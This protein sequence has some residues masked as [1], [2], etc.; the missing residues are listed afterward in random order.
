M[1]HQICIATAQTQNPDA[2]VHRRL[3]N[4]R[5]SLWGDHFLSYSN[6]SEETIDGLEQVQ[7]LKEEVQRMLMSPIDSL[8]EKL[9]LIDAIQRLGVSYHFEGEIDE[10][11]Q[12]IHRYHY[13]CDVQESD[14]ALYTIALHF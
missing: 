13:T 1:S 10:V 12:Q 14:D 3:A 4:F 9:E 7:R 8:L 5:P 2:N 6:K 11:L